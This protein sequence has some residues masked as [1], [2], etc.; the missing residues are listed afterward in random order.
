[1]NGQN[2]N[3]NQM[4]YNNRPHT[5]Q[6]NQNQGGYKNNYNQKNFKPRSPK[7]ND[8]YVKKEGQDGQ[9]GKKGDKNQ[10]EK[11][12]VTTKRRTTKRLPLTRSQRTLRLHQSQ[13]RTLLLNERETGS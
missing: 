8:R 11:K 4:P 9:K 1:M 3:N 5:A 2:W 13:L 7:K 10:S 6:G 12:Y